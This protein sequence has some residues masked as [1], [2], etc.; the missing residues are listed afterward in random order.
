[1]LTCF[2]FVLMCDLELGF[3]WNRLNLIK[4]CLNIKFWKLGTLF[5]IRLALWAQF[6]IASL[7]FFPHLVSPFPLQPYIAPIFHHASHSHC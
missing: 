3:E 4:F 1:M 5:Y 2:I 7:I 6:F